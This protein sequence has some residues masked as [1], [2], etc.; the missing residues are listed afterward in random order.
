MKKR[1][2][3]IDVIGSFVQ[4]EHGRIINDSLGESTSMAKTKHLDSSSQPRL[5]VTSSMTSSSSSSTCTSTMIDA[6]HDH[7]GQQS[8][9]HRRRTFIWTYPFIGNGHYRPSWSCGHAHDS[10]SSKSYGLIRSCG[11]CLLIVLVAIILLSLSIV[12]GFSLYLAIV[13]N[14]LTEQT[15]A[16]G[17]SGNFRIVSGDSFTIR[18][19]NQ[20]SSEFRRKATRYERIMEHILRHS[21]LADSLLYTEI[22]TFR[23]GSLLVFFRF[24][25]QKLPMDHAL[26]IQKSK[27]V[28]NFGTIENVLLD[29][30]V[31]MT[32]VKQVLSNSFRQQWSNAT[33]DHSLQLDVESIKLS[34]FER[35]TEPQY[36]QRLKRKL[37]NLINYEPESIN[38]V[39]NE[40]Q[41]PEHLDSYVDDKTTTT[42]N[43]SLE[44]LTVTS[45]TNIEISTTLKPIREMITTI[46]SSSNKTASISQVSIEDAWPTT[47]KPW[48]VKTDDKITTNDNDV[49]NVTKTKVTQTTMSKSENPVE[50]NDTSS[51]WT[52]KPTTTIASDDSVLMNNMTTFFQ[53]IITLGHETT[54]NKPAESR[55]DSDDQ[56]L[57]VVQTQST[58]DQWNL[59]SQNDTIDG[60]LISSKPTMAAIDSQVKINKN[61][62]DKIL[63]VSKDSF[64]LYSLGN[65]NH[66]VS[67]L[68]D[69]VN[70]TD[71]YD[72]DDG[73]ENEFKL[74]PFSDM[75]EQI[76][77]ATPTNSS[78]IISNKTD[79]VAALF[80][81]ENEFTQ[82]E[83]TT[84]IPTDLPTDHTT[85]DS[86]FKSPIPVLA[87]GTRISKKLNNHSKHNKSSHASNALHGSFYYYNSIDK[88][89]R[90]IMRTTT[91]TT[92][93]AAP[94]ITC[95]VNEFA[96]LNASH[97]RQCVRFE[98]I[99]DRIIDCSD[100][101]DE[102]QCRCADYLLRDETHRH[103]LCDGVIDCAD[104]SDETVTCGPRCRE[105]MF[106]C[107]GLSNQCIEQS[108]VCDGN[109]D[110]LN[111]DDEQNCI[112]LVDDQ[113]QM[114]DKNIHFSMDN[115]NPKGVLHIQHQ[116][117]WAPLC[118]DSYDLDSDN[119]ID[120]RYENDSVEGN[121]T[122]ISIS[123][124]IQIDDMGQAVC[125]ANYYVQLEKID[126]VTI[127]KNSSLHNLT[128]FFAIN[129]QL[130]S[131][132]KPAL[133]LWSSLF[134]KVECPGHKVAR[135]ECSTIECG[136]RP[137]SSKLQRRI[138]GGHSSS[139]GSWPW[140]VALYREGE[141]QC[142][143]VVIDSQW[144]LTAAHCFYSTPGA[145]WTARSGVLRRGS[146]QKTLY[147]EIRRIDRVF[148]HPDYVD[149]GFINDIALLHLDRPLQYS[150]YIRPICLP[151]AED[152]H[153]G[154]WNNQLCTTVGWGKLYENGR[155]FPDTL[156]EVTL[157]IISTEECRKRTLFL[158]LYKITDNMFCAGFKHGG[159]DACLGDSGGPIMCQKANGK[160]ILLG[161][162]SNGDGCGRAGRPG[163]YTKV[164]NYLTWI[165]SIMAKGYRVGHGYE[166]NP[167]T[168]MLVTGK[169][170]DKPHWPGN[171]LAMHDKACESGHRCPLGKC[172]KRQQLCDHVID[173]YEDSSDERYCFHY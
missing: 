11:C 43:P 131:N 39:D 75:D 152:S 159:R 92:T 101:S 90:P 167:K 136:I 54:I 25:A 57:N 99:C 8:N 88:V 133:S 103:K 117:V 4:D 162:T 114:Q 24:Y 40:H 42:A 46:E 27:T 68:L 139:F 102:L 142:G 32:R 149:R 170:V 93:T 86:V 33:I 160:W 161:I 14:L 77:T 173:C 17:M 87:Y 63:I 38:R 112:A 31:I 134:E 36:R 82:L 3:S 98:A 143:A 165:H 15:F 55:E 49:N 150:K 64:D 121:A 10:Q 158:P 130:P 172:L 79:H 29:D 18:L 97:D 146:L 116:G 7:Y 9:D 28:I 89:P 166:S 94:R 45:F 118:F 124:M 113:E 1:S 105:G 76:S 119:W 20:T 47:N 169:Q 85:D 84:P 132:S 127:E 164:Y 107:H 83:S 122:S 138:I 115:H 56:V 137:M 154:R 53:D 171:N 155:I 145:F 30:Q 23:Q 144:L 141:F 34:T 148:I 126:I 129:S 16:Y 35:L 74:K 128:R 2:N 125:K 41:L 140:Q 52:T 168:T 66:T 19:L 22:Y 163:V 72:S 81:I 51:Q 110:C 156:Q 91:T 13:T 123:S 58:L 104:L 65:T 78:V 108:L 61:S 111:G 95:K 60:F 6:D 70:I 62:T 106:V 26:A 69:S 100:G 153:I 120:H 44:D 135:I 37:E 73:I 157:P 12:L 59:S 5:E 96:C 71:D 67:T 80:I 21:L 50:Q 109:N 147:E 151:D 48:I